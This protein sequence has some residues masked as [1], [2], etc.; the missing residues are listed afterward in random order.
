M[1]FL[2]DNY[3]DNYVDNIK[4]ILFHTLTTT[5][6]HTYKQLNLLINKYFLNLSTILSLPYY[7]YNNI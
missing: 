3:V 5:Y 1:I 6:Q 2:V 7:Y 4:I